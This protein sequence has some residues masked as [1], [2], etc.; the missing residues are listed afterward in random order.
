LKLDVAPVPTQ[1]MAFATTSRK[2][3]KGRKLPVEPTILVT[4]T[5][6]Q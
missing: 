1:G 4:L 6:R 2:K 3:A 5:G